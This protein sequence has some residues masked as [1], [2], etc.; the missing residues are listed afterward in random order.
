MDD[1]PARESVGIPRADAWIAMGMSS[2]AVGL[3][4]T[5]RGDPFLLM[6]WG[7][8]LS[9]IGIVAVILGLGLLLRIWR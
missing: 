2:L 3:W 7:V 5:D 8:G 9:L 1:N 6:L 4:L